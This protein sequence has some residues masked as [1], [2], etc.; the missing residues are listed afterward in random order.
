[1]TDAA[2]A[3]RY[4]RDHELR[5]V[6][7]RDIP[8][9][10]R[11]R[12]RRIS[13]SRW[14]DRLPEGRFA[15][16]VSAPGLLLVGAF[17]L[18]P[19]LTAFGMSFF[20]IELLRDDFMPFIGFRNY[21]VRLAADTEFLATLPLTVGFAILTSALAVP[22]ALMTAVLIH[23]RARF[24]GA[25]AVVL[26]LPWAIAP[27][28]DG[29]LWRLMFEPRTG[30]AT[31]LLTVFGLPPVL[32]R[33]A[34]GA[35]V[36]TVVAVTWRAIPLL[37]ILFLGALRLVRTDV[38]RAARLDGA[39]SL[40]V[41]RYVTLPAIA[42]VVIAA[43]LLQVILA[44]QV[45]EVQY[46][47]SSGAPPKGSMLAGFA[48]FNT[49]I[50]EISLGYGSAM[51]M[52]IGLVIAL[53]LGGLYLAVIRPRPTRFVPTD[54]DDRLDI[55]PA[56]TDATT[57]S[58]L[59]QEPAPG[60]EVPPRGSPVPDRSPRPRAARAWI[61][62][63]RLRRFVWTLLVAGVT[64][65]LLVGLA[66]PIIWI[67]VASTQPASALAQMPPRLT[68][69]LDLSAYWRLLNDPSWQGAAAVSITVTVL[70]TLIALCVALLAGYPLARF[71]IRGAS[72]LLALLLAIMLI[73]P[74][75]LA[76]PV[77]YLVID[78]GIR[79]TVIGLILINA[80]FWSPILIWLVRG[81]FIGVPPELERA[82]RIDGCSRLGAIF[83]V[84]LP[85]AAPVIAAATAIVFIGIWNDFVFVAVI[86][87]RETQTLP[88]Y[89]G[90][91]ASPLFNVFAA[92]IVLTVAPCIAIIALLRT[93]ILALR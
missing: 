69:T 37:A 63:D 30:I 42:P 39:S 82:A 70:A 58:R 86:G 81:A 13:A 89:L 73:P 93:R 91:S 7:G 61:G 57:W 90:E 64:V 88:R 52:I 68:T 35:L 31:Y 6:T 55:T 28:A 10:A 16:V 38:R 15:L 8:L 2:L 33:E 65:L 11:P 25:L 76:I 4:P 44:L 54:R 78:L 83:R 5:D 80:A 59:R 49:V 21:A 87:G 53:C 84:S 20:R 12:P 3:N 9:E 66:G 19:I 79:G 22:L 1:V 24:A 50:G 62:G 32:I 40:Q 67:G 60:S 56:R 14:L 23:G 18:P 46:A 17:V 26:L 34:A 27:I 92:R 77:L 71:R 51:T 47:L 36:A 75:A 29:I 74:I 72:V 85:A 41:F 43:C 45:F 48:I